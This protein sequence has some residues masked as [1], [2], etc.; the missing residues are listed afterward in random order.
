MYLSQNILLKCFTDKLE[1][2]GK[3]IG[4]TLQSTCLEK[5]IFFDRHSM[6]AL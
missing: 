1:S 6:L 3:K 2:L 4:L 5:L